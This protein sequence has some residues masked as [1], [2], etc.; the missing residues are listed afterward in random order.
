MSN[1]VR[2]KHRAN[3]AKRR[4]TRPPLMKPHNVLSAMFG[5]DQ[6]GHG[7]SRWNRNWLSVLIR[8]LQV[9]VADVVVFYRVKFGDVQHGK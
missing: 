6:V 5:D 1:P 4:E 2:A 9:S 8:L 3:G 7:L